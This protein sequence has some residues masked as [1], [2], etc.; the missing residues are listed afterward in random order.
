MKYLVKIINI[1]FIPLVL[2]FC[3]NNF[4][5]KNAPVNGT[6]IY[7][8]KFFD[9]TNGVA[10][11]QYAETLYTSDGGKHWAPIASAEQSDNSENYLWS[12]EINCSAMKT[13]D[14]GINWEPYSLEPQEHFCMAYFK[15]KNTGLKVAEEFL[16]KVVN[17]INEYLSKNE[18]D[19]LLNTAIQ[20]TEYYTNAQSGWALGWC[21][22]SFE[23]P[24]QM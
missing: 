4:Y 1:T 24:M 6:K 17:V 2:L 11:S 8:I 10:K 19:S 3:Q 9:S 21:I 18:V 14:G 23:N 13:N 12:A 16:N 20:C 22:R 7:S 5:W 15:D